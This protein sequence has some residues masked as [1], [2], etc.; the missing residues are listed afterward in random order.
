MK[1]YLGEKGSSPEEPFLKWLLSN[2]KNGTTILKSF[3]SKV[4]LL[5]NSST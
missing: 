3:K 2:S 1:D 5:N 4:F